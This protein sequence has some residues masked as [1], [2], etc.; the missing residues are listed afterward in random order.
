MEYFF[1]VSWQDK[2]LK[3]WNIP[4]RRQHG[5]FRLLCALLTTHADRA[6]REWVQPAVGQSKREQQT[7]QT[8]GSVQLG[9]YAELL[10]K[11]VGAWGFFLF[12]PQN[13]K[14]LFPTR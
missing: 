7:C 4:E 14:P 5:A 11:L 10:R 12:C 2:Q 6:A 9:S 8:Q 3:Q 13:E 1:A